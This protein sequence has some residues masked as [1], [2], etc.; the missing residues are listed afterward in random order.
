[1]TD[2]DID[3]MFAELTADLDTSDDRRPFALQG[4]GTV[5]VRLDTV[6]LRPAGTGGGT[7]EW[8][9][10]TEPAPLRHGG[11]G[12]STGRRAGRSDF[13]FPAR[14]EPQLR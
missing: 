6:R 12:A 5:A 9:G 11:W 14:G 4:D 8:C 7:T 10:S 3:A 2:R 13:S 1:M